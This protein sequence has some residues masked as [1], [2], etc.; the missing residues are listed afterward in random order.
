MKAFL[1]VFLFSGNGC[2]SA[3]TVYL[4]GEHFGIITRFFT[5]FLMVVAIFEFKLFLI[6]VFISMFFIE[7]CQYSSNHIMCT[8]QL[9]LLSTFLC[10]ESC[11]LWMFEQGR[12]K[13][14]GSRNLSNVFL[15]LREREREREREY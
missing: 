6:T 7:Y 1:R 8:F 11:R 3:G 14:E 9:L 13:R 2:L 4:T 12:E 10:C 5:F 15:L